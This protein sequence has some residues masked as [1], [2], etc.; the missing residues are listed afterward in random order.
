V[1]VL[2]SS[3]TGQLRQA[4]GTAQGAIACW[5]RT[6]VSACWLGQQQSWISVMVLSVL[7]WRDIEG[8]R[9]VFVIEATR[10]RGKGFRVRLSHG[11]N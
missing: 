3:R 8:R 1:S 7:R 11:Q 5:L 6:V 10:P 9:L 2:A 4:R